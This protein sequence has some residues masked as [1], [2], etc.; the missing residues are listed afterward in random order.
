M[1]VQQRAETQARLEAIEKEKDEAEAKLADEQKK[2]EEEEVKRQEA[3]K[4]RLE[5]EQA[6][7]RAEELRRQAEVKAKSQPQI[8]TVVVNPS[9][10]SSNT[11][12]DTSYATIAGQS[13]TKN[14]RSGPGT[15]YS[16]V[17]QGYTGETIEILESG[18]DQGGYKW[19]KVYHTP[20]GTTGWIAAQLINF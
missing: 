14:I 15:N 12:S 4:M 19:Y 17:G 1:I 5:A 2:R 8:R 9:S 3:D 20:S 11:S 6:R 18:Y 13:G 16:I 10:M 7:V